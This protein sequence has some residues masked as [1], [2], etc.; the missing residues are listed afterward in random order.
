MK[1]FLEINRQIFY[2][3]KDRLLGERETYPIPVL[4]SSPEITIQFWKRPTAGRSRGPGEEWNMDEDVLIIL[5]IGK[6][7]RL[8]HL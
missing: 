6:V 2:S 7:G 4:L 3:K 8:S 5:A 1:K